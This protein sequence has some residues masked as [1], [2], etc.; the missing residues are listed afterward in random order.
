M[1]SML[2]KISLENKVLMLVFIMRVDVVEKKGLF[3]LLPISYIA[4]VVFFLKTILGSDVP[5]DME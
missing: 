1:I 4:F 3:F 2:L 5:D